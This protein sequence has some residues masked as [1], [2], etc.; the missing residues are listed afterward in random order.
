MSYDSTILSPRNP[1]DPTGKSL[2][3][4]G[5]QLQLTTL[6]EIQ[7]VIST[8]GNP[9]ATGSLVFVMMGL[10]ILFTPNKTGRVRITVQ[11]QLGNT[12]TADGCTVQ[13]STGTGGA[14]AN[15]AAVT[16]TQ[17]GVA[18]TWT[19]LTGV[20]NAPLFV[21]AVVTGLAIG[22]QI[23]VDLAVKAVTGGSASV[24]SLVID[25]EEF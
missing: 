19:S 3:T 8:P 16:G 6:N 5:V 10:A 25:I 20:L 13:I 7:D 17:Q 23:W 9:A 15:G 2:L 22:T 1:R 11:G 12:T 14:P 18:Q 4:T 24:T 21:F